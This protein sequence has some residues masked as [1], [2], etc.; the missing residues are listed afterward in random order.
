MSSQLPKGFEL[1]KEPAKAPANKSSQ[2][3]PAGFKLMDASNSIDPEITALNEQDR[4]PEGQIDAF[5]QGAKSTANRIGASVDTIQG[6]KKELIEGKE[7]AAKIE[8]TEAQEDFSSS[9]KTL[10]DG[11]HGNFV[12][13]LTNAVK[14]AGVAAWENPEGAAD[15][16][17][18]QAPNSAVVMGSGFAG[19]K[20]G[21][22]AGTTLGPA[23]TVVGALVGGVV[24]MYAGNAMVETGSIAQEK[25]VDGSISDEDMDEA[26]RQGLVKSGVI[27]GADT[28]TLGLNRLIMG[29]PSRAV[30]SAVKKSLL[31]N[32]VDIA[33]ESSLKAALAS[34]DVMKA[35]ADA[36]ADAF[37]KTTGIKKRAGRGLTAFGLEMSGEGVG[38]YTG[39]S[40]A[41]LDASVSDAVLESIMSMPMSV[42]ELF[43]AKELGRK[44]GKLTDEVNNAVPMNDGP[45][46]PDDTVYSEFDDNE[47][48][49]DA[50]DA[51]DDAIIDTAEDAA[52]TVGDN[53]NVDIF[54]PE[55]LQDAEPVK[56]TGIPVE[57]NAVLQDPIIQNEDA[58]ALVDEGTIRQVPENSE[59]TPTHEMPSGEQV[60]AVDGEDGVYIDAEGFEWD[61]PNAT[62]IQ[63]STADAGTTPANDR[64]IPEQPQSQPV[65][66][67]SSDSAVP[68]VPALVG[69]TDKVYTPDNQEVEVQ[70]EILDAADLISSN[71]EAGNLNPD[72]PMYLQPRDRT[73]KKSQAQ[74]N[75]L[76]ADINPERLGVTNSVTDGAPIIGNGNIVESGNGRVLALRKAYKG[77]GGAK[78]KQWLQDN[79]DGFGVG[80]NDIKSMQS[81]VLVRRRTTPMNE[82]ERT[83]FAIDANKPTVAGMSPLESAKTDAGLIS[84]ELLDSYIPSQDGNVLAAS[85]SAF[86]RSFS[87]AIGGNDT[88]SLMSG[89]GEW[90]RQMADRVQAAVFHKAYSNDS[91]TNL[92]AQEADPDIK[93]VINALNVA[94]PYFAKVK[95]QAKAI[96]LDLPGIISD[97]AAI[98]VQAKNSKVSVSDLVKQ[99]GW[100]GDIDPDTANMAEFLDSYSR[101]SKKLATFFV[102]V[103]KGIEQEIAQQSNGDMFERQPASINDI[104]SRAAES[105]EANNERQQETTDL[106]SEAE[107]PSNEPDNATSS[108]GS[109]QA[110]SGRAADEVDTDTAKQPEVKADK[111]KPLSK[112]DVATKFI[113]VSKGEK[114]TFSGDVGSASTGKEYTVNKINKDGSIDVSSDTGST[115]ISLAEIRR[116]KNSGVTVTKAEAERKTKPSKP[117]KDRFAKNKIFTNDKVE[118]AKARMRAKLG[119]LN[120]GIDPELM[121]DG[122]T[123]TGAYVESGLRD[124]VEYADLMVSDFGNGIKPYLVSFWESTRY[125]PSMQDQSEGM[126][127][128]ATAKAYVDEISDTLLDNDKGADNADGT[129]KLPSGEASGSSNES[130]IS[131]SESGSNDNSGTEKGGQGLRNGP[132]DTSAT[133]TSEGQGNGLRGDNAS[134]VGYESNEQVEQNVQLQAGENGRLPRNNGPTNYDLRDKSN[135]ALTP[136]K[137][138]KVNK[139]VLDILKKPVNDVTEADKEMLRQYTGNGGLSNKYSEDKGAA[140][141]NQHYTDYTTIKEMYRAIEAAGIKPKKILEPSVGSGN[142]IGLFPDA[143]WTA[144]DIDADN[145]DVVK[146]LYPKAKVSTESYETFR[147]QGFDLIISNVPFASAV[148]LPREYMNS[149][150]PAFKAIHN[151]FFAQSIDK[152]K[153]GGII[154]FMTST[155]TM[156]GSTEAA[157]LRKHLMSKMDVIGAFRLPQGTQKANASTEVMIDVIYLQKRPDG[158]ETKQPE[159]NQSFTRTGFKLGHKINQYFID[160]PMSV[161]GDIAAGVDKTKMGREGLIVTGEARYQDMVL[162]P[163]DYTT[164]DESTERG[165][166]RTVFLDQ[167]AA[168]EYADANGLL[169]VDTKKTPFFKD[170]EVYDTK[171]SFVDVSGNGM[172]GHKVTG[173]QADKLAELKVIDETHDEKLVEA[174]KAKHENSPHKDRGLKAWAKTNHATAQL[175][176]LLALFDENYN[177]S[178]IFSEQV[179]FEDSGKLEVTSKSSLKDR[180]ESLEDPDGIIKGDSDL[181]SND[182][183]QSLLDTGKYARVGS[184]TIQNA[185]LYYAGNIY[186]KVDELSRV[187]PAQQRDKQLAKLNSVMPKPTPIRRIT[188]KGNESW[189]PASAKASLGTRDHYDG[190]SFFGTNVFDDNAM[191]NLYNKYIAGNPIITKGKEELQDEY[192]ARLRDAQSTL[193]DDV[194]PMV[195]QHLID[196]GLSAEL[197]DQY[198]R[199]K[200]FFA[201]PVFDGSSLKNLPKTFRGKPFSLMAHQQEGAE[202]AIYNKKGVIAFSPG[203]GKTPTAIVVA[204][205]L[206]QKGVIKKPIF[207]VPANTIPQW[208]ESARELYPNAK[209]FEFPK[210][211]TGINK[212]KVKDWPAM[213]AQ[214]KEKMV[215]DLTNNRYDYTFISSNMA[216]KFTIP[217]RKYSEYVDRLV[218]SINGMERPDSELTKS[219]IKAKASRIA[220]MEVLKRTMMNAR[221][222][223]ASSGFDM[224]T[225]GFDALFADEV[226]NYK[227]IGMQSGDAKGGIGAD[228]AL[229]SKFPIGRDGKPDKT[230]NPTSVTL[231]SSRSYDF[232]FKTM[233]ISEMNNGNNV[234]LLTGTPTPNKPLELMTLLH[235]LDTHILDEYGIENVGDFVDMFFTISEESGTSVSG[236][237][238]MQPEL[239]EIKNIDALNSI[240]TRYVDYR[241][242]ES[243]KDLTRPKQI[244]VVHSIL[245]SDDAISVFEDVQARLLTAIEDAKAKRTGEIVDDAETVIQMYSAGR[246][247]S[248]DL[249]L[250]RPT[251][252]STVVPRGTIFEDETRADYSKIAKTVELVTAKVKSNAKAGQIIF[253][254][255]LKFAGKGSTHS[256]IR[257]KVIAATGLKPTE[258]SY[259][260]GSAHVNPKTGEEVTSGPKTERLQDII[261]AYNRGE[262]KVIIGN[263]AK[264]GVGVDLQKYTTDIY[265]VDKPYRPD[266]VEQRNNRGV[267]QGNENSEVTVHTF[268]Q[269]GTFDEMSERILA[270]KQ[271]F[272]DIYWKNQESDTA[273]IANEGIPDAYAAAIELE[274]N[275]YKKKKLMVERDLAGARKKQEAIEKQISGIAKRIRTAK[276]NTTDLINVNRG[277]DTR[278][279][280]A[281]EGKTDAEK[282]PLIAAFKKRMTEQKANNIARIAELEASITALNQD[283]EQRK[284]D[285]ASHV[286]T[287]STMRETYVVN[288]QV[289]L[290][291]IEASDLV[292]DSQVSEGVPYSYERKETGIQQDSSDYA[293]ATDLL[294]TAEL[295][296]SQAQAS[297]NFRLQ[298]KQVEAGT[299]SSGLDTVNTA[300]DAAHVIASIRKH[301][302]ET[303]LAIVTDSKGKII[304]VIRHSKGDK[305]SSIVAVSELVGAVAATDNAANVWFAHNHPSGNTAPSRSD[306]MITD[307]LNEAMSGLNVTLRNHVVVTPDGLFSVV[308]DTSQNRIGKKI[309]PLV[310][311]KTI[312]L[313]ERVIRKN[314][315]MTDVQALTDA[316]SAADYVERLEANS[317]LLLLNTSNKPIGVIGL[318][319][320][321]LGSLRSGGSIK[322]ILTA[323]SETNASA[324]MAIAGDRKTAFNIGN[325][326]ARVSG[327]DFRHLDTF[328]KTDNHTQSLSAK[329]DPLGDK[330]SPFYSRGADNKAKGIS[331]QQAKDTVNGFIDSFNGNVPLNIRIAETQESIYGEQGSKENA[332][333]IKGAYHARRGALVFIRG[334]AHS[335]S[336]AIRTLRHEVLGH[337]GLNTFKPADKK[338]ILEKI[339]ASKN[340]WSLKKEWARVEDLYSDKS[341]MEQAEEVFAFTIE[342]EA[343]VSSRL[344]DAILELIRKALKA[345]GIGKG[346][347]TKSEI[348]TLAKAMASQIRSGERT[349]QTFPD[350]DQDQFSRNEE[351]EWLIA[352]EKGLSMSKAARMSRAKDMGFDVDTVYYHGT[353]NSFKGFKTNL[354]YDNRSFMF[355]SADPETASDFGIYK[356]SDLGF[357]KKFD[358]ETEV[359]RS[360]A[361]EAIDGSSGA[362][363][364]PVMIR[365][366]STFDY[367]NKSHVESIS[368]ALNKGQ[369]IDVSNGLWDV[370][371]NIRVQRAIRNAGF[372]SFYVREAGEKNLAIYDPRNIRSINAAFDPD[373]MDTSDLLARRDDGDINEPMQF[374]DDDSTGFA[375]PDET[376]VTVVIRKLQ[377]KHKV[378]KDLQSN[379][380]DVN[381]IL[382]EENN[383]YLAEEAFHGKAENDLDILRTEYVEPLANKLA[384]SGISQSQLDQYLIANHAK[385][386]NDYIA[387]INP[388][389]PDGGS[390]M[391]DAEADG[392]LNNIA[393]SEMQ[394]EYDELASIIYDM[395]ADVRDLIR[396]SGLESN[397][398]IDAWE[399]SYQHYVPLKG[400]ASDDIQEGGPRTGRGFTI[401]G[402][403]SKRALGRKTEAASPSTQTIIDM[404]EKLIRKRKNEVGNA[405]LKLIEDNPNEEYWQIFTSDRPEMTKGIKKL[406]DGDVVTDIPVPM[407]MMSDRYF[408]TK[409]DG[410]TYYIKLEDER[411]MKA[412]KNLGVENNNTLVRALGAIN[413]VLSSLNTSYSPEFVISNFSRDIQTAILNLSAEQTIDDGKAKGA[414]IVLDVVRDSPKSMKAIYASLNGRVLTGENAE[415]QQ[416]FEEF[417]QAGAKT[418]W[419]DMK[420]LAGQRAELEGLIAMANGTVKGNVIKYGRSVAKFVENINS[421]VE[422][423]VR[424]SAFVNARRAGISEKQAATLAKNMTVN[425]NRKGEAGVLMNSLY[426]FANASVQGTANFV[427]TMGTMKG[428]KTLKWKNLNNAQRVAVG[429]TAGAFF[430]AMANRMGAGDDDDGENWYDKVAD[431]EKERNIIIMKSLLGG[432]QDGTYWKIPL[433][434]GYNSFYVLGDS[435]ESAVTGNK[436]AAETASRIALAT[437]GSFSPIGFQIS[438]SLQGT[439]LK[440]G[441]PTILKPLVEIGLNENFMGSTI[442]N[443]NFPFGTP[444]PDASL[445]RRHTPEHYKKAAQWLNEMSG[446]SDYRSGAIDVNPDT[447]EYITGYFG[448]AAYSFF[449]TKVP[450]YLYR[451]AKGLDTEP[452]RTPFLG[453]ISG[454]V[455]PYD[456]AGNFFDRRDEIN[457]LKDEAENLRGEERSDFLKEYMPKIRLKPM[458]KVSERQLKSLRKRRDHF[459]ESDLGIVERDKNLKEVEGKMKRIYD[460]FNKSYANAEKTQ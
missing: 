132:R 240:I 443:E 283:H 389:M 94:A 202:R 155:G 371:E 72:F 208:E 325:Y 84:D 350:S 227:N 302:Q 194:L 8:K 123:I 43:V 100:F 153:D 338:A 449:G 266:E 403:E 88:S 295:S 157:K 431:Y 251:D 185:R 383:A 245:R 440:N 291:A 41:G 76:A 322:R 184:T 191:L 102:S 290:S 199:S 126:T 297:D 330:E 143:N 400:H 146:R 82:Q 119:Q 34:K 270:S 429:I 176:S 337:Y 307:R 436:S 284:Q 33:Q 273:E 209:I 374:S 133:D 386:R 71:D 103:A 332:G 20:L 5:V 187:K 246:D 300:E 390:G 48:V 437:L 445:G 233:Y 260:S 64:G 343:T 79:A 47:T 446:G 106:F 281:Y 366:K 188:I 125:H 104:L 35:A 232:R 420:D 29:A 310:R 77:K 128:A 201:V 229:T 418:G 414:E 75:K 205:Q 44:P 341:E 6:D 448:G 135:I 278:P 98:L 86:L 91:L 107:K 139:A 439:L 356:A 151:F 142:F 244:D 169:F 395:L 15:E 380:V 26:L 193:T 190:T 236:E 53:E 405:F 262:I 196:D 301:A 111:P 320:D 327:S 127:D 14:S 67:P 211:K 183:I 87:Q 239:T 319:N 365:L 397:G 52:Y 141:F 50:A 89:S 391:S 216:Q 287:I 432:K 81:P 56:A 249:R 152:V 99:A 410:E 316:V 450:N 28:A 247:A 32:G 269:V 164:E 180:A 275:P 118:A 108:D 226:Q 369:I 175:N 70:Y 250:Y 259:V 372:D 427:R 134:V 130:G 241:S 455:L 276:A 385:E 74:I 293:A 370:I 160:Y 140:I 228:V 213:S 38:E 428:D 334:N 203:L 323:I 117:A 458:L 63:D 456:D 17:A 60:Q 200:N 355:V 171:I 352:K 122:L 333:T 252:K 424:L 423:S 189:L 55:T 387:S 109:E 351:N 238:R 218:E 255:R 378:L 454:R 138:E 261:D 42:S 80:A 354:G 317:G 224:Q 381:G 407:A 220:K 339:I 178:E 315:S 382:T 177:L 165:D 342:N 204:D 51:N 83:Q 306:A 340:H 136:A 416:Y 353:A 299:I 257:N 303:M 210:F 116:A 1:I 7:D 148:S 305:S 264:L 415:W 158:V 360:D 272:N 13:E 66:Q 286:D 161:L 357:Q 442:Y 37:I 346:I 413:R 225:L 345:V 294:V 114:V 447:M 182:E 277:I 27:T 221:R 285:L 289:S 231:G 97:A 335:V 39:S 19:A 279:V 379:I 412:M 331:E 23:G 406:A 394:P 292:D 167:K 173:V 444:K 271:G 256:D 349:Q 46:P 92:L 237:A 326:L 93:N 253:L 254:D 263:T 282:K 364:L 78:Y 207:I 258:V 367:E 222:E 460:R 16:F 4:K 459:Y 68:N 441:S 313:T 65:E 377:D 105:V 347:I 248:I 197:E 45:M 168:Q 10:T 452:S 24:G 170:G 375:I 417:K 376:M 215:N 457:Q 361:E 2:S 30:E 453:R 121:L 137:R 235:H 49:F 312:S 402:K 309:T 90:T 296:G 304:N 9:Y 265:Q 59:F 57:D 421:A 422:N 230:A 115:I 433:P 358:A 267:R 388:E 21:A 217:A 426:M 162:E 411:L 174:Y 435:M 58:G 384:K 198:N 150:Q 368:E 147:G 31:D 144:V 242:P 214:D 54:E 274:S 166:G 318:T 234:F 308:S 113:T 324:V 219:Q 36:G 124:F 398:V 69:A 61:E 181:L 298:Y 96:G 425:F 120:S 206:L 336:D 243:A 192:N 3:L 359:E 149:V 408:T 223:E 163:V 401:G 373:Y 344:I 348:R 314:R 40:A 329:G 438:E 362:N 159:K 321:E 85:N 22:M 195:R 18:A 11:E 280:P 311:D 172:F 328:I 434:Y 212:G 363:V 419:F 129:T 112:L 186:K 62:A 156:D 392:I 409:R 393:A 154:A 95:T 430:I 268:T 404:T 12:G 451:T 179:R 399:E 110:A 73:G 25:I 288:G 145:T 396:D 131:N 101:S